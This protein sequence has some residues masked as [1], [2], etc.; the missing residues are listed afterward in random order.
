MGLETTKPE[1]LDTPEAIAL[2]LQQSLSKD[3]PRLFIAAL[4]DVARAQGMTRIAD[5][6]DLR[7]E[8]L[9]RS[10]NGDRNVQFTTVMKVL[11][12]DELANSCRTKTNLSD[13][14]A[15]TRPTP[16]CPRKRAPA[17]P[18][19]TVRRKAATAFPA[20]GT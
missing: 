6:T 15:I 11:E 3:D 7:R 10:L 14:K 4:G 2:Y 17:R 5:R 8:S 9:Y 20:P 16:S 13:L 19:V 18:C 12:G 1:R